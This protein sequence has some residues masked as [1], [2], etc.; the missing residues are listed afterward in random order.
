MTNA[1]Q[2]LAWPAR[3]TTIEH[4]PTVK[5]IAVPLDGSRLADHALARAA[6]LAADSGAELHILYVFKPGN[7]DRWSDLGTTSG[8]RLIDQ[9]RQDANR[10]VKNQS[11]K[12][13]QQ[14]L[15]VRGQWIEG[16][17]IAAIIGYL[18]AQEI[19]LVVMIPPARSWFKRDPV[20]MIRKRTGAAVLAVDV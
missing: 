5:R 10:Y 9:A 14:R 17:D 8:I 15:N 19:D 20:A 7:V 4:A 6:E 11:N 12:L 1:A 3:I 2:S 18:T 16:R 13:R